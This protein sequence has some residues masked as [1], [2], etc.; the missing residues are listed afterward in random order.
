MVIL[1]PRH[2]CAVEMALLQYSRLLV[3]NVHQGLESR[4]ES[5]TFCEITAYILRPNNSAG[6]C[7][8]G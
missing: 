5:I 4:L 3:L 1:Y 6:I 7:R 8:R 2:A